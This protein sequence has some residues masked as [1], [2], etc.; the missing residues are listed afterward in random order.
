MRRRGFTLIELLV[1]IAIIAILAAILFPVFAKARE[2]ARK[3]ACQSNLK[4]LGSGVMMYAQDYDECLP[5]Y[6]A[7]NAQPACSIRWWQQLEPYTKSK[8]VMGCSSAPTVPDLN[9]CPSYG[10]NV[11]HVMICAGAAAGRSMSVFSRP[12]QTVA[13]AD[14]GRFGTCN[15]PE[16]AESAGFPC[17]YCDQGDGCAYNALYG[18]ISRRH[19][20]GANFAFL[21]GHVKWARVET[22]WTRTHT[23]ETDQWGHYSM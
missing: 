17:I 23:A 9:C 2:Q 15:G 21:D 3:A 11:N 20:G 6:R 8:A 18:A 10:C 5:R 12:A 7:G 16:A 4:Q 1:V 13:I 14:S 22:E 19:G